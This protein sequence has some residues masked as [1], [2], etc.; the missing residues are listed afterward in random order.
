MINPTKTVSVGRRLVVILAPVVVVVC[1]L[2]AVGELLLR[3]ESLP[4]VE[5]TWQRALTFGAAILPGIVALV[6][7]YLLAIRFVQDLYALNSASE[8]SAFLQRRLLGQKAAATSAKVKAGKFSAGEDHVL[9]RLGG[10]ASILVHQDSAA[11][12]EQGGRLTRVAAK[13]STKLEPFER[14]FDTIDLRPI[15]AL[16]AIGAL[17]KEGIPVTC[18]A[19]I[20]FQIDSRGVPPTGDVPFPA[21]EETVF[22]A[23]TSTWIREHHRA[24]GERVLNWAQRLVRVEAAGTLRSI[25]AR[26]PLDRLIGLGDLRGSNTR[27]QIRREL[28]DTLKAKAPDLGA[29][30]LTVELGDIVVRDSI[31]R[32]WAEAWKADWLRWSTEQQ[33]LGKA[34]QTAQLE[35]AKTRAQV[36]LLSTITQAFQPLLTKQADITSRLVLARLF[37]VLSRAPADPK[38]RVNLPKEAI[39]TLKLLKELVS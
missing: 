36:M 17:S 7:A 34:R 2:A 18:E 1:L 10:P 6:A 5:A 21:S 30:I 27:E 16:E 29:R 24:E 25:L 13:G 9:S 28:S 39:N 4:P 19:E 35:S 26:Y 20:S 37:M 15:H 8:A 14:V 22:T 38:T 33:G 12:L 11:L 3:P 32:Q 23:A 31:T